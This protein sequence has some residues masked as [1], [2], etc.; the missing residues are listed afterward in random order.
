MPLG[1]FK[2]AALVVVCSVSN[3]DAQI[4]AQGGSEEPIGQE[5]EAT[6]PGSDEGAIARH[7]RLMILD[8]STNDDARDLL[9]PIKKELLK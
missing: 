3:D 5:H 4:I 8:G 9:A 7:P 6:P 2:D 1:E